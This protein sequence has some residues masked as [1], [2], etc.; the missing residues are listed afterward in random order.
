MVYDE[1]LELLAKVPLFS[2]CT[3]KELQL[4]GQLTDQLDIPQGDV[5]TREGEPGREFYVIAEGKAKVVLRDTELATLGPG[6]FFGEMA[7]VD[8][9]PRAATITAETPMR[10]Y[11][12]DHQAFWTMVAEAPSVAQSVMRALAQRLRGAENAPTY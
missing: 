2:L 6:D 4:I 10:A 8:Q 5:L 1:K 3:K 7:I 9:G 11:L 12:V